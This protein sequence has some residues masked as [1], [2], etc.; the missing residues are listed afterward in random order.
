MA[1]ARGR[2]PPAVAAWPTCASAREALGGKLEVIAQLRRTCVRLRVPSEPASLWGL[3]ETRRMSMRTPLP[4]PADRTRVVTPPHV[5]ECRRQLLQALPPD[6][7]RAEPGRVV[8]L[9]AHLAVIAIGVLVIARTDARWIW[10]LTALLSGQSFAAL[11]FLAHDLSHGTIV[12]Q[13]WLRYGLELLAWS[14]LLVPVT[15]WR[16]THHKGHHVG[17]NTPLDQ[18]RKLPE[19]AMTR[20]DRLYFAAFYPHGGRFRFNPLL[21][22]HFVAFITRLSVAQLL[23][24]GRRMPSMPR[25]LVSTRAER[26][27]VGL[28]LVFIAL[29]QLVWLR[30]L[31][32]SVVKLFFA[33]LLPLAV[34]SAVATL[35]LATNHFLQP[36]Q[37]EN[38]PLA[39]STTV[40]VPRFMDA[41]HSHFSHHVE[42]HLFPTLRSGCYPILSRQLQRDFMPSYHRIGMIDAWRQLLRGPVGQANHLLGPTSPLERSFAAK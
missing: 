3:N 23:W 38:D 28:E 39:A 21:G 40:V 15:V 22:L 4:S 33:T 41:L 42:H 32:G 8:V 27:R 17:P 5:N 13:R 19:D 30:V 31:D 9:L 12:R 34:G 37:T 14:P 18:D 26:V 29:L 2:Q 7:F 20:L 1:K 6:S 10:L 35:Y 36:H 11:G 24:N 16:V 25:A